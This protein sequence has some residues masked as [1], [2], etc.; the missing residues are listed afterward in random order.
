MRGQNITMI[1][2]PFEKI[3]INVGV[4]RLRNAPQFEDKVMPELEREIAAITGQK[5]SPRSAR[6]AIAAFKTRVGDVIGYQVTLRG[7]RMNDFLSRLVNLALPRVKDFRG[8]DLHN[9]DHGGNLNIGFKEQFS[10]PEIQVEQS[11]INFGIQ[12][13]I[14]PKEKNRDKAIDLYRSVGVPLK[15]PQSEKPKFKK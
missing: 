4:G 7:R 6:K 5:P 15:V 12:V 11:R 2:K 9:I 14:V 3:V 13:T 1:N 10:F 8:I